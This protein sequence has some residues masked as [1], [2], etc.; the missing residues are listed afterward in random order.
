[1]RTTRRVI[2][3]ITML[4][5]LGGVALS[6]SAF[7]Q[8]PSAD[9]EEIVFVAG[10]VND[11]RTVNPFRAFEAPEF[12][13]MDLNYDLL[14]SFSQEDMSPVPSLATSWTPS[15]DGL[16]WTIEL[17]DD[18]TWQDGE[19]FTANDV[20]FTFEFI[21]ENNIAAFTNYLPFTDS[22]EVDR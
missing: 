19:P 8:S 10:T 17:R 3:A 15:E 11:M 21:A 7:A 22:F 1:M 5:V 18:V 9:D 14:I 13:V 4:T 20:V 2:A 6:G 16:T 12:E